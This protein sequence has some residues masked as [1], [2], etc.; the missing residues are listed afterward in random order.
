MK[1]RKPFLIL[2][3]FAVSMGMSMAPLSMA[4]ACSNSVPK[5]KRN[6]NSLKSTKTV[7][8]SK[9]D[10]SKKHA[11]ASKKKSKSTKLARTLPPKLVPPSRV[12]IIDTRGQGPDPDHFPMP[13][14]SEFRE[15]QSSS[16]S[17]STELSSQAVPEEFREPSLQ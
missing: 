6:P 13:E 16:T 1:L 12:R 3:S 4:E 14:I 11:K 5:S 2:L 10:K 15:S 9:K 8:K 7:K 17:G